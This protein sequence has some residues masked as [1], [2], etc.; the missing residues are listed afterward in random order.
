MNTQNYI[1]ELRNN[2]NLIQKYDKFYYYYPPRPEYVIPSSELPNYENDCLGQ[3][4]LNGSC[5]E[6]YIQ[7]DEF[8]YFGRHKNES[9]SN[10][11]LNINDLKILNCGNNNWNVFVGEYMNKN[12]NGVDGKPW[13]HKFVIFDVLVYNGEYLL[14]TTFEERVKL[15]DI[16]FGTVDENEY[17]YKI[18]DKI[19]RVKSFYDNFLTRWNDIVKVDMLE[20][21]VLKKKNQKLVK[22][23]A[24]KNNMSH[25]CRKETKNYR[26]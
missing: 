22:A 2:N 17:L 4:K 23:F 1:N 7:G 10:F 18:T 26:F 25:K 24:E 5:V 12:K 21:F 8:R 15:L 3:P 9:I 19:F 14:G 20:G 13:N 6:I 16:L 11:N